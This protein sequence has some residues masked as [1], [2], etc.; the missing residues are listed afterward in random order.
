MDVKK[1]ETNIK[2]A[3]EWER[4]KGIWRT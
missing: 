3:R 4:R 2:E 1:R